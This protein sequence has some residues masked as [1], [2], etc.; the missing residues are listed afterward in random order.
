MAERRFSVWRGDASGGALVDYTADVDQGMVVLDV[1]HRIQ[2]LQ[3][4]DLALRWNCKAG[5]CGSCGVEINGKPRLSCMTR[6]NSF[7]LQLVCIGFI[8]FAV[9]VVLAKMKLRSQALG[10]AALEQARLR[11]RSLFHAFFPR[12]LFVASILVFVVAGIGTMV[13][14]TV[15]FFVLTYIG[16]WWTIYALLS[17]VAARNEFRDHV[18]LERRKV[19]P[20]CLYSLE[21]HDDSGRCPECGSGFTPASLRRDWFG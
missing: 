2:A 7:E 11:K 4:N 21:G 17:Y 8:L 14:H 12:R 9:A 10:P 3:A 1:L 5:K 19:C 13:Y 6:M 18:L 16:L 20:K 15:P